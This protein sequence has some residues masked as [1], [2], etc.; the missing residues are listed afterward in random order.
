MIYDDG[1]EHEDMRVIE[2]PRCENEEF[3]QDAG[4][5]KICGLGAYNYCEGEAQYDLSGYQRIQF[6]TRILVML[7]TVKLVDSPPSFLKKDF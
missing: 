7:D 3:S 6:T 4:Y 2:C 1:V 5:C